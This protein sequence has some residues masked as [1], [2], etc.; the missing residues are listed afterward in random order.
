MHTAR[1]GCVHGNTVTL[2]SPVPA[3]EGVRVR[4]VLEPVN[5]TDA[6]LKPDA[7]AHLWSEWVSN[8]P[9]G[10]LEEDDTFK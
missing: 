10:P 9:Q 8:G 5:D 2:D 4:V 6:A 1:T 7:Q 3:L